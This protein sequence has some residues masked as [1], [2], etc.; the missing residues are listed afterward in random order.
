MTVLDQNVVFRPRSTKQRC[1]DRAPGMFGVYA[2]PKPL[3]R[4]LRGG[5]AKDCRFVQ[6]GTINCAIRFVL[7]TGKMNCGTPFILFNTLLY[8]K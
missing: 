4:L 8:A 3:S 5:G 6:F 1:F 7:L 2:R